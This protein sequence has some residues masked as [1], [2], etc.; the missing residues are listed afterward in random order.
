MWVWLFVVAVAVA[1][2]AVYCSCAVVAGFFS[3]EFFISLTVCEC[4][5]FCSVW[6]LLLLV[7]V[8]GGDV[9]GVVVLLFGFICFLRAFIV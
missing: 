4:C 5:S 1:L 2:K 8:W 7:R 9:L 6:W 3:V